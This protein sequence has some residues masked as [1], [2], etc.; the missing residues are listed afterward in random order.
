VM[1]TATDMLICMVPFWVA[2]TIGLLVGWLWKPQWASLLLLGVK[3]RPR[4]VWDTPPGFGARRF[5][6]AIMA[7]SALPMWKEAWKSFSAWM[8]PSA[9]VLLVPTDIPVD[10]AGPR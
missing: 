10:I 5:W 2:T 4:L 9:E 7:L 6:L 1:E 3:S 8:W